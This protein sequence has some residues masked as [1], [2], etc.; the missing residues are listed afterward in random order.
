M[1]PAEVDLAALSV[2]EEG[3]QLELVSP[4]RGLAEHLRTLGAATPILLATL[5][6]GR[7]VLES[8][9]TYIHTRGVALHSTSY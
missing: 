8:V 9:Y 1:S 2:K 3:G 6:E 5:V 7:N 4:R